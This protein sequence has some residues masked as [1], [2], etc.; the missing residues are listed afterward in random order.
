MRVAGGGDIS[1]EG[2]GSS[3]GRQT[4][5]DQQGSTQNSWRK[6][7]AQAMGSNRLSAGRQGG[8]EEEIDRGGSRS[9][10]NTA[11]SEEAGG[12]QQWHRRLESVSPVVNNV[13]ENSAAVSESEAGCQFGVVS[14]RSGTAADATGEYLDPS[15]NYQVPHVMDDLNRKDDGVVNALKSPPSLR[16]SGE[17]VSRM[18][19]MRRP[20][21][22]TS[23]HSDSVEA[24][25]HKHS[26]VPAS[27]EPSATRMKDA[28]LDA[29]YGRNAKILLHP[30]TAEMPVKSKNSGNNSPRRLNV[31]KLP[32]AYFIMGVNQW[33]HIN[34]P[35]HQLRMEAAT[36]RAA[37]KAAGKKKGHP[38]PREQRYLD[39]VTGLFGFPT[40][41]GPQVYRTELKDHKKPLTSPLQVRDM[42][43]CYRQEK[44]K[45]LVQCPE[46]F[47]ANK[48]GGCFMEVAPSF[49]CLGV[50]QLPT[51][52]CNSYNNYNS[53][54]HF[55][56]QCT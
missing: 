46:G 33:R 9:R 18:L 31:T 35:V 44:R 21:E 12:R 11:G 50:G 20:F 7:Q 42:D 37:E 22:A 19:R 43:M 15:P 41:M 54:T 28:Q 48:E 52:L 3:V 23:A 34:D 38:L 13:I 1:D 40:R 32:Y 2:K 24:G 26:G 36:A 55:L 8:A 17:G 30:E 56:F 51:L 39:P 27:S 10:R 5:A 45:P 25:E 14:S 29:G 49:T 4:E 47:T 6:V 53:F 16:E